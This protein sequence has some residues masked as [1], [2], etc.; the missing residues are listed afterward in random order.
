MRRVELSR[1][2]VVTTSPSTGFEIF[3]TGASG[4]NPGFRS[5]LSQCGTTHH[6]IDPHDF[7]ASLASKVTNCDRN[8]TK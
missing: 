7:P 8:V 3:V 5:A 4:R 6:R 1:Y 2:R